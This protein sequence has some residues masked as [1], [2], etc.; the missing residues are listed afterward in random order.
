MSACAL[1][2]QAPWQALKCLT[3]DATQLN[4]PTWQPAVRRLTTSDRVCKPCHAGHCAGCYEP[5]RNRGLQ[6]A[7]QPTV[8]C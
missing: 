1:E 4:D 5:M 6:C 2:F 7:G 3:P 8:V